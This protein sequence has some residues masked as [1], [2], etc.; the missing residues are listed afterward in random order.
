MAEPAAVSTGSAATGGAEEG[1]DGATAVVT[2]GAATVV[3][4][5]GPG[6]GAVVVGV[7]AAN[8]VS[9]P[10]RCAPSSG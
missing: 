5:T 4:V 1:I 3:V 2:T 8:G 9:K 10:T 6:T 7:V